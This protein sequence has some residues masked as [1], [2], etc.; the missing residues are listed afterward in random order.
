MQ[1][2][3][4]LI[5]NIYFSY[6][7]KLVHWILIITNIASRYQG[8][9][10]KQLFSIY[11]TSKPM[12]TS[13]QRYGEINHISISYPSFTTCCPTTTTTIIIHWVI[14]WTAGTYWFTS[15][16]N[17]VPC[18]SVGSLQDQTSPFF[19]CNVPQKR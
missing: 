18:R 8:K 7:H 11:Y 12:H 5:S 3:N 4:L 9:K 1:Y 10:L 13:S 14:C 15:Y 2:K 19:I 6:L 17:W 16:M